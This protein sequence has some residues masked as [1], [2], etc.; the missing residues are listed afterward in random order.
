MNTFLIALGGCV[1]LKDNTLLLLQ[2]KDSQH[3]EFPGG[4]IESGETPQQ[5]A[6]RETKEELGVD[7]RILHYLGYTDFTHAG[8]ELR[9][10]KV[11]CEITTGT[12]RITE[13]DV[14]EKLEWIALAEWKKYVLAPNVQQFCEQWASGEFTALLTAPKGITTL[15]DNRPWGKFEQFSPGNAGIPCTVK[16]L[17]IE[18]HQSLSKQYHHNRDEMWH[19]LS[20]TGG[21]EA[22]TEKFD[23]K[24][25]DKIFIKRGQIHRLFTQHEKLQ[26][27]ELAFGRFD[28]ADIVR[29]QDVYGRT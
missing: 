25:E 11:L 6:V 29:L 28:E 12:P 23:L 18:P 5:A 16:I 3:L 2:R 17:T 22:G 14:F 10:F 27:L 21:A 15:V 13:P 8:K 7:V 26:I 4:K 1:I 19:V 20:G 9:S 24:S